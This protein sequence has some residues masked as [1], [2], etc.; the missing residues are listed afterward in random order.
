MDQGKGQGFCKIC[1]QN[2]CTRPGRKYI[3]LSDNTFEIKIIIENRFLFKTCLKGKNKL[4]QGKALGK[5][6]ESKTALK[7]RNITTQLT[8]CLAT[9]LNSNACV[10]CFVRS[11]K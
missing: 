2:I 7:G 9:K 11:Q 3:C 4:T 10:F 5:E 6:C 1:L 8:R